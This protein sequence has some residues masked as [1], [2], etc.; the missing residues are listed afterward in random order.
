[1]TEEKLSEKSKNAKKKNGQVSKIWGI[2]SLDSKT[3]K[4]SGPPE[5]KTNVL[6]RGLT[7]FNPLSKTYIKKRQN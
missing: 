5:K 6:N 1:M 3:Q 4:R 7:R 2:Q